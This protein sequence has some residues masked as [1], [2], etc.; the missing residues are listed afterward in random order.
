MNLTEDRNPSADAPVIVHLER[1]LDGRPIP[2]DE[3]KVSLT[4]KTEAGVEWLV[5]ARGPNFKRIE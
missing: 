4:W 1:S 2:E 5:D 3:K